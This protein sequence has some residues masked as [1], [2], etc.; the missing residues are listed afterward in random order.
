MAPTQQKR[1][2]NIFG[3]S[4][5]VAKDSNNAQHVSSSEKEKFLF[6]SDEEES[7]RNPKPKKEKSKK[8]KH[9]MDTQNAP[10][11]FDFFLLPSLI[12]LQ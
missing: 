4:R 11:K 2:H 1:T 12:S 10:N 7:K 8:E 5:G 6:T 3:A 9:A